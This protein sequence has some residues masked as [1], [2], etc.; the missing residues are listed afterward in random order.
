MGRGCFTLGGIIDLFPII[1]Q[2]IPQSSKYVEYIHVDFIYAM[3]SEESELK[4]QIEELF[5][6]EWLTK[7]EILATDCFGSVNGFE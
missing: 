1:P 4:I 6:V 7:E 3:V 5:R 2:V